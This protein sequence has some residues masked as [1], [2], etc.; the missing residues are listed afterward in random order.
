MT[1]IFEALKKAQSRK[2]TLPFP[3]A[4]LPPV[5]VV[6][7]TLPPP[8]AGP[9]GTGAALARAEALPEMPRIETLRTPGQAGS[10]PLPADA[11]REM[12]ALRVG[13]E[14]AIEN[15]RTRV[16]MF[17]GS[18]HGEGATT[19]ATQ[20]AAVVAAE[21]RGR[22]LL[23][24]LRPSRSGLRRAPAAPR[25]PAGAPA[26][27]PPVARGAHPLSLVTVSDD[28]RRT[29]AQGSAALRGMI[30]AVSSQFEWVIVDGP[31]VLEAPD[32]L[33]LASIVDG[34][35][36]VVRSGHTKRPVA[37]RATDLLR[38]SGVRILG[39]VLNRRRLEIPDFIYRRI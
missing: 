26:V 38:K 11:V 18:V 8:E 37:L 13:L 39:T 3:P 23:V 9:P 7:R 30:A 1:R 36:L 12:T 10:A 6:P 22:P 14:S 4:E 33:D 21:G 15:Q 27:P 20:F 2:G 34:A 28:A 16:V 32:A 24:D 17:L 5:Q 29:G 31:P 25:P 19:V 35:V